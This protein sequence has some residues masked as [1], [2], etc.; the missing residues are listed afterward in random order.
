[1]NRGF[2][3]VCLVQEKDIVSGLDRA[4]VDQAPA[5]AQ[6]GHARGNVP[7]LIDKEVVILEQNGTLLSGG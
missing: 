5:E 1:M 3:Y 6:A 4:L 7:L 2:D